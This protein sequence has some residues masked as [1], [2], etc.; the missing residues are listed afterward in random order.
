MD[1]KLVV[2]ELARTLRVD[3]ITAT[4]ARFSRLGAERI[5]CLAAVA[6]SL[7]ISLENMSVERH[8][9]RKQCSTVGPLQGTGCLRDCDGKRPYFSG[10][11]SLQ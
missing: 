1:R 8:V 9:C 2:E 7:S 3:A 5:E 6:S 10:V 11:Q 4:F